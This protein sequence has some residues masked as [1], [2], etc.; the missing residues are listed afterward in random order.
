MQFHTYFQKLGFSEKEAIIYSTL[1]KLGTQPASTLARYTGFERT[2]VYKVLIHF[3]QKNLVAVTTTRW[4]KHFFIPD[5]T[6]LKSYIV[7]EEDRY[8]WLARDFES[9]ATELQSHRLTDTLVGM[10]KITL[11]EG[12]DWVRNCY[13]DIFATLEQQRYHTC[14]LFASNTLSS[15]SGKSS[16]I[17]TYANDFFEKMKKSNYGIDTTLGNGFWLMETVWKTLS[18]DAL[19]DLPATNESIQVYITGESVYILI[20][21][22]IPFG[23]KIVSNELAQVFYFLLDTIGKEKRTVW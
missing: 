2:Y 14:K 22:E 7:W 19:R 20:F 13:E 15:K 1:Y 8:E 16:V 23:I 11:Y 21:R 17:D 10:P 9:V 4:V 6:V 3:T 5:I 18:I 12:P